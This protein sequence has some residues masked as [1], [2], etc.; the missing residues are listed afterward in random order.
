MPEGPHGMDFV[1]E[2]LLFLAI[3]DVL[4]IFQQLHTFFVYLIISIMCL[5]QNTCITTLELLKGRQNRDNQI[6]AETIR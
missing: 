3:L 5:I 2:K 6:C 1:L 4:E